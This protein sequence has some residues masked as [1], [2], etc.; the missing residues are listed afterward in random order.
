M[1]P[2]VNF[3]LFEIHLLRCLR[4][5]SEYQKCSRNWPQ[6]CQKQLKMTILNFGLKFCSY[7][8]FFS[9]NCYNDDYDH[10]LA[11]VMRSCSYLKGQIIL[12]TLVLKICIIPPENVLKGAI[13][14]IW[15]AY[16]HPNP[17]SIASSDNLN[18]IHFHL[19]SL[20]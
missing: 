20:N 10:P 12:E 4:K 8:W 6:S 14:D 13:Q 16:S 2:H 15:N 11:P 3:Q 19:R 7:K 5:P 17:V 9:K 1:D 18:E